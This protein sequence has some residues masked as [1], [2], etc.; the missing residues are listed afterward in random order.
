MAHN[1]NVDEA[2]NG[3]EDTTTPGV[4]S[5]CAPGKSAALDNLK[6][7]ASVALSGS[8]NESEP[9]TPGHSLQATTT[10]SLES[11]G[12]NTPTLRCGKKRERGS[13]NP[14]EVP[15]KRRLRLSEDNGKECSLD[16]DERS[17]ELWIDG[18]VA[19]CEAYE[20]SKSS[21]N[22]QHRQVA[23]PSDN[24][25]SVNRPP[26]PKDFEHVVRAEVAACFQPITDLIS[27]SMEWSRT[28]FTQVINRLRALQRDST[29]LAHEIRNM[30]AN[31]RQASDAI[32]L[33]NER[34]SVIQRCVLE[35]HQIMTAT[36]K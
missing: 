6:P 4:P 18:E 14:S 15:V 30:R 34:M 1:L 23:R 21:S 28:D 11:N 8:N 29:M 22:T 31:Q 20:L 13:D 10:Q 5:S 26:T 19:A 25:S 12:C 35:T 32:S 36:R 33:M 27:L 24:N 9:V 17:A 16:Y 3:E 7:V 2:R